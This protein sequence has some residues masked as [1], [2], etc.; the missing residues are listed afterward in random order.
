MLRHLD[1][2]VRPAAL[3]TL[4]LLVE[5]P[6][7]FAVRDHMRAF[8]RDKRSRFV[9][10]LPNEIGRELQSL[11]LFVGHSKIIFASTVEHVSQELGDLKICHE[12]SLTSF[13]KYQPNTA[14]QMKAATVM[15]L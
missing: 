13:R 15:M 11:V 1:L 14:P 9:G 5:G 12:R 6:A 4:A 7:L 8:R 2:G 3:P 10:Y